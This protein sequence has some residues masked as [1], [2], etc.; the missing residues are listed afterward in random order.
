MLHRNL[1]TSFEFSDFSSPYRNELFIFQGDA[2]ASSNGSIQLTKIE[3]GKPIPNSVGRVSYGLPVRLWDLKTQK[4]ASFTTSFSF[5]VSPNGGDG[6]SFFMAPFHS[7]IPKDSQGG[8]LGLFNPDASLAPFFRD[9]T[10][11]VE[12]DTFSNPWD[13]AFAHIGIDVNS[14]VSV[15]SVPWLNG[16]EGLNTTVFATVSYEAVTQNLSVVVSYYSGSVLGGTTVNASLSHVIDLRNVLP[17]RVG[18]RRKQH[19]KFKFEELWLTNEDCGNI[20]EEAWKNSNGGIQ[21]KLK[22]CAEKLEI[23][24][25]E[26][27]GDIPKR[28]RKAQEEINSINESPQTDEVVKRGRELE[29]ELDEL[30]RIDEIRWC[31]RSRVSWLKYGDKN[32]SFFHQKVTQRKKRN[33]IDSIVDDRGVKHE[34]E[35]QIEEIMRGKLQLKE[36]GFFCTLIHQLWKARNQLV[37]ENKERPIIEEIETAT[38]VFKEHWKAQ[39]KEEEFRTAQVDNRPHQQIW[40]APP[41]SMVK[42]NVD[43]AKDRDNKGGVGVVARN[44]WGQIMAAAT[45]SLPFPLEAHE[46]EAYAVQWGINFASECCFTEII[47]ESDNLEVVKAL[48]H[49]RISDSYFGS[50][51]ADALD[52]CKKFRLVSFSH[53]K[54]NG[55][56]VAHELAQL[57]I[58]TPNYVWMEEAPGHVTN[59]AMCD[60]L[61]P[62]E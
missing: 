40:E 6:I 5:L 29:S 54:R 45:W 30:L 56:K 39:K 2:S 24:G 4:L 37:F 33:R 10:V 7:P 44:C 16:V 55:N 28:I 41:N 51:I 35:E 36:K 3:N 58:T 53:V 61:A 57:A 60:I 59:L 17:E 26:T 12:F 11:A 19:R 50:F 32:T 21:G 47:V 34:D 9:P 13:P 8:Y 49:G 38:R 43:A 48:K 46:A 25:R 42:I 18:K 23:W 22:V 62:I 20:I 31:Q 52:L 1:R 14:I 27:F 15:T